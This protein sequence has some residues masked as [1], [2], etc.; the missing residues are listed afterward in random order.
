MHPSA[1]LPTARPRRRWYRR[2]GGIAAAA[3]VVGSF[4]LWAYAFSGLARK[5]PP[6]TLHDMAYRRQA[7]ALCAPSWRAVAALPPAPAEPD[8]TSRA[9]TL[10]QA[11]AELTAMVQRLRTITPDNEADRAIVSQWLGDWDQYLR[12]RAE[13]QQV[14][15][16]GRD[17][18]FTLT[19]KDGENYTKSM[20]NL[21]VVNDMGSCAT[22]GDV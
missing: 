13:H 16:G 20:D 4:A 9:R 14:L 1:T 18:Q 12:D 10:A 6:D 22:P 17:A 11:N 5:D 19:L 8:V 3:V 7:E 2:P 15:A 21:A